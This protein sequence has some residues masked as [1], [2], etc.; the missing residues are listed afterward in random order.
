MIIISRGNR[1]CLT[2]SFGTHVYVSVKPHFFATVTRPERNS[3]KE[4]DLSPGFR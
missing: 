2:S 3:L 4:K 1:D